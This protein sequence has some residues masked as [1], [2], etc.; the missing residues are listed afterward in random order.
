MNRQ[1][2]RQRAHERLKESSIPRSSLWVAVVILTLAL[3]GL[4]GACATMSAS[5]G[6]A[7]ESLANGAGEAGVSSTAH[8]EANV[9]A[10][11]EK[12][13]SLG[14]TQAIRATLPAQGY[15]IRPAPAPAIKSDR[16]SAV[17][18]PAER[19]RGDQSDEPVVERAPPPV[20]R[21]AK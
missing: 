3:V 18:G 16:P 21:D 9:P 12:A 19:P 5:A 2:P 10:A 17:N 11:G 8:G 20:N 13:W 1:D 6:L 4:S 15:D 7:N 14:G